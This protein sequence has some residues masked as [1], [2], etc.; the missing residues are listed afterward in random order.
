MAQEACQQAASPPER[1]PAAGGTR[2]GL[3]PSGS[4]SAHDPDDC[5][6]AVV[7]SLVGFIVLG[8]SYEFIPAFSRLIHHALINSKFL[9]YA[10]DDSDSLVISHCQ[11]NCS[12]TS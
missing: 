7:S 10:G 11:I 6:Q 3:E 9:S 8:Y 1:K 4:R 5:P 2:P 12:V